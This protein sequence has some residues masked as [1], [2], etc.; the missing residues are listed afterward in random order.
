MTTNILCIPSLYNITQ[1]KLTWNF[2]LSLILCAIVHKMVL[3]FEHS[4]S[5]DTTL[6]QY[7]YWPFKQW[8]TVSPCT[9]SSILQTTIEC[10]NA[11][12]IE[13][14]PSRMVLHEIMSVQVNLRI[15]LFYM[16]TYFTFK[17]MPQIKKWK[18]KCQRCENW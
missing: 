2:A 8:S 16:F 11:N 14:T 10:L 1:T 12:Y 15:N 13:L 3:S 6:F 18:K 4:F 17:N 5:W 7:L 9:M